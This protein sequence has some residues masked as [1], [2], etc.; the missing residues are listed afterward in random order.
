MNEHKETSTPAAESSIDRTMEVA[1]ERSRE[2]AKNQEL[3]A[4]SSAERSA[5]ILV[6]RAKIEALFQKEGSAENR[7]ANLDGDASVVAK[8]TPVAA[9]GLD[10]NKSYQ[11]TLNH[12]HQQLSPAERAFSKVV[13]NKTVERI[14]DTA[15][16][17]VARPNA[18]LAGSFTAFIAVL[19]VYAIARNYGYSLSGFETIAAFAIGWIFGLIYDYARV[20]LRG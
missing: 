1:K 6:E 13:H 18:I 8:A 4:Q 15:E 20:S 17:T 19:A 5:E 10:R 12:V 16:A 14:S 3:N 11:Q 9:S 7:H 2:L